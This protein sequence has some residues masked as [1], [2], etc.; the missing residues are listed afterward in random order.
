MT[1]PAARREGAKGHDATRRAGGNQNLRGLEP[2]ETSPTLLD[3]RSEPHL[4]R[5]I[6]PSHRTPPG[7]ISE[8]L[9]GEKRE[10]TVSQMLSYKLHMDVGN[11]QERQW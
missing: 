4:L 10:L 3:G 9:R 7:G 5:C 11:L 6:L 2:G 1:D 8:R